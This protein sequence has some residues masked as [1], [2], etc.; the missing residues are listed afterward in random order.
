MTTRPRDRGWIVL[1]L[2]A[3]VLIACIG[4]RFARECDVMAMTKAERA[5][6]ELL[7]TKL[8]LRWSGAIAPERMPLPDHGA[9]ILGWDFNQHRTDGSAVYAAW[10]TS[11]SHGDGHDPKRLGSQNGRQLYAT[12][13]DALIALRLAKEWEGAVALRKIDAMIEEEP[14]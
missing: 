7:R 13:R 2:I 1:A 10:T 3:A 4:Q 12:K 8:A 14:A 5:E 11:Y 9:V 6:L